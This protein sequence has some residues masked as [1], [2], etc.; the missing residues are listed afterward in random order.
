M[1]VSCRLEASRGGRDVLLVDL[2][3]CEFE[4]VEPDDRLLVVRVGPQRVE[5][6]VAAHGDIGVVTEETAAEA[7]PRVDGVRTHGL[8]DAGRNVSNDVV[9]ARVVDV[10]AKRV[11]SDPADGRWWSSRARLPGRDDIA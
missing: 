5:C 1:T 8:R 4:A 9:E 11:A 7:V 3:R 2:R 6:V 10:V